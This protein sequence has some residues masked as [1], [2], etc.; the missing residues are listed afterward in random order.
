[1]L[2]SSVLTVWVDIC[3]LSPRIEITYRW[4]SIDLTPLT[5]FVRQKTVIPHSFVMLQKF[6][7]YIRNEII[8]TFFRKY[9]FL[10]ITCLD[11]R[12]K[13]TEPTRLFLLD[14]L[15]WPWEVKYARMS[16][17]LVK[18]LCH[19]LF[20][21]STTNLLLREHIFMMPIHML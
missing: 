15:I 4:D 20:Q 18:L 16:V 10:F 1:M 13:R 17:L 12:K 5:M 8:S 9:I 19:V 3:E 14:K 6:V 21:N 11:H 7:A 2:L